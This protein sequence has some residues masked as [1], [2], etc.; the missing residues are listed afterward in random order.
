[1]HTYKYTHKHTHTHIS[2]Y[3]KRPIRIVLCL[4]S[5]VMFL[6]RILASLFN[7]L[8]ISKKNTYR[9]L[10][11]VHKHT[12]AHTHTR[13]HTHIYIYIQAVK[14]CL[15]IRMFIKKW[16]LYNRIQILVRIHIRMLNAGFH[17]CV[18]DPHTTISIREM[19]IQDFLV[20][21]VSSSVLV[22]KWQETLSQQSSVYRGLISTS[23]QDI[24]S[25]TTTTTSNATTS[26]ATTT[27][28]LL[29]LLLLLQLLLLL[30]HYTTT[31]TTILL[32]LQLLLQ[33]QLLPLILQLL[34]LLLLLKE[35]LS[36]KWQDV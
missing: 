25:T 6:T 18:H 20:R 19:F 9:T 24:G 27:I 8:S 1:M 36:M 31:I 16:T 12:H 17:T 11:S 4:D 34:L 29:L 35:H 22:N 7:S 33:I 26:L 10:Q 30:L 28:L 3:K 2:V 32:Q 15:N 21:N 13:T 5:I 23:Q 14:K